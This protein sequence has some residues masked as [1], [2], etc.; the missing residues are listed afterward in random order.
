MKKQ[1]MKDAGRHNP[2]YT[3]LNALM[4]ERG[5][6]HPVLIL[7]LDILDHNIEELK[8]KINDLARFR[9]VVK[10]LPCVDLI[11][12]ILERTR[13][14]KLMVF[15]RPFLN[16][17]VNTFPNSDILLGKPLPVQA[18]NTFYRVKDA[19]RPTSGTPRIQW[20]IDTA[21]RL[22]QY[23]AFARSMGLKMLINIEIDVGLR[24]GGIAR[25]EGLAPL[26]KTIAEDPVHLDLSG[27]MG[28]DPHVAQ[29]GKLLI[30]RTVALA[31]VTSRYKKFVKFLQQEFPALYNPQL[32]FNGAG[33]PTFSL[34]KKKEILND[35]SAGSVL[36][37]PSHLDLKS[38]AGHQ[39]AMF[40]ATPVLK[41]HAG[42]QI[43]FLGPFSGL[44]QKI[45]PLWRTTFFIYGG[46]WKAEP[47]SPK[48]LVLNPLYGRSTNQEMMNGSEHTEL[49]VD[50][51][52]FLRP[53]QSET[54]MLQFGDLFVIRGDRYIGRWPVFS[55]D[56]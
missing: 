17:V 25:P 45:R 19:S 50:D 54:V 18:V 56:K 1:K 43:P 23:H 24:R 14:N 2:Y 10:S 30:P 28:Y 52:V 51:Y 5:P 6:G 53:T 27:F 35:V 16:L 44:M 31:Q 32:T 7:D 33:S 29:S 55:Q 39:A 26:L 12:H 13:T 42:L 4:K 48:G 11:R 38:L 9:L 49:E 22:D 46:Y 20:L 15:H 34:Y 37:K 36:V 8:M 21:Q 41:K 3:S 47:L 40:I